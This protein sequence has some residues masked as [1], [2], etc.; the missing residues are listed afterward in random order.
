MTLLLELQRCGAG[1]CA[2]LLICDTTKASVL[3]PARG[4]VEVEV[5]RCNTLH[6]LPA[7]SVL[8]VPKQSSACD[9]YK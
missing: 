9:A 4:N 6:S 7:S 8:Q 1:L 2:E 5:V 3:W